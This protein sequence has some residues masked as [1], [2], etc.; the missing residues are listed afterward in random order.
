MKQ[1]RFFI[2]D[3]HP[4]VR[5]FLVCL[6]DGQQGWKVC[7]TAGKAADAVQAV[8]TLK[9]DLAIVDLILDDK[10]DPGL[11]AKFRQ[12]TPQMRILV[13]SGSDE[14]TNAPVV[15]RAGAQGYISKANPAAKILEAIQCVLQGGIYLSE[16][17]AAQMLQKDTT[18][19]TAPRSPV[20]GLSARE[21]ELFRLIGDGLGPSQV[22]GEMHLSVKTVEGYT[23]RLKLK[24]NQRTAGD[25]RRYAIEWHRTHEP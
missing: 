22:A 9:P 18:P 15:M 3:D 4:M 23:A 25:L 5:D 13:V 17:T 11:V 16:E 19:T 7:G 8:T 12:L 24:L 14:A 6:I 20:D 2:V 1:T 10:C 21:Q